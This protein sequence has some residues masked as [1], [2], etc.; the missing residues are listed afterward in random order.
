MTSSQPSVSKSFWREFK[1]NFPL[2]CTRKKKKKKKTQQVPVCTSR[3]AKKFD[4]FSVMH[5]NFHRSYRQGNWGVTVGSRVNLIRA[6]RTLAR[7]EAQE[8]S[9]PNIFEVERLRTRIRGLRDLRVLG[10][11]IR[12]SLFK[13]FS[14]DKGLEF[15]A[16]ET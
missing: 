7:L 3:H 6:Q 1:K 15:E 2:K 12:G 13:T 10:S 8:L 14:D 11:R 5:E 4:P 16:S 9:R